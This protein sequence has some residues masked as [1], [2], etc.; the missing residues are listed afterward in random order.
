MHMA[1]KAS[2]SAARHHGACAEAGVSDGHSQAN[3]GLSS[4]QAMGAGLLR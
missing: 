1:Q 4:K 2:M 3:K